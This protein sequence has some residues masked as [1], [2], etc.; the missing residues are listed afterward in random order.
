MKAESKRSKGSINHINHKAIKSYLKYNDNYFKFQIIL[1]IKY[2]HSFKIV[3]SGKGMGAY[4]LIEI[5][6]DFASYES[7]IE[8]DES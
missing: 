1:S 5:E 7:E 3:A 4:E 6:W 8:L 2:K